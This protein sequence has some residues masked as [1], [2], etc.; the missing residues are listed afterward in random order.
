[1]IEANVNITDGT[2]RELK[3]YSLNDEQFLV[4]PSCN[5]KLVSIL[6]V[7]LDTPMKFGKFDIDA[8]VFSAECTKCKQISFEKTF[9]NVKLYYGVVHPH[10]L[11]DESTDLVDKIA[12]VHIKVK[13]CQD[14][15]KKT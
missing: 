7:K 12:K 5:A 14:M 11:V 9:K 13:K 6:V 3:G 2:D 15:T 1:M 4:C 8:T 10:E